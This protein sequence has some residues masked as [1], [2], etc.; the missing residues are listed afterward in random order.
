MATNRPK[1][2]EAAAPAR[3]AEGAQERRRVLIVCEDSKSSSFYFRAFN[4]DRERAEILTVGTG[5]NTDRLV[6]ENH[7]AEVHRQRKPAVV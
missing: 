5:M 4:I 2:W 6:N 3:R 7:S 1:P